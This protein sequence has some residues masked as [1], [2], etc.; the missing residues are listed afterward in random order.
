MFALGWKSPR[1]KACTLIQLIRQPPF[2]SVMFVTGNK[3]NSGLE[4]VLY[5]PWGDTERLFY[6]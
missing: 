2:T 3:K 6:R 5:P 1:G 4:Y